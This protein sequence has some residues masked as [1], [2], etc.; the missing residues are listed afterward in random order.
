MFT[1]KKVQVTPEYSLSEAKKI[2]NRVEEVELPTDNLE[3]N[4]IQSVIE[5][6]T[7]LV[8]QTQD[9]YDKRQAEI[10]E[11]LKTETD[12]VKITRLEN[13]LLEEAMIPVNYDTIIIMRNAQDILSPAEEPQTILGVIYNSIISIGDLIGGILRRDANISP[14]Q[15]NL[16]EES[17]TDNI[18]LPDSPS[19]LS[20]DHGITSF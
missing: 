20:G 17:F 19:H 6:L 4:A 16:S 9:A 3:I 13:R 5:A 14:Y 8:E 11:L 12:L 15:M 7:L 2:L 1:K 18:L 10:N